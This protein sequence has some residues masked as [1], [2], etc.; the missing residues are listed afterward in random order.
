MNYYMSAAANLRW[1]F[2]C[3]V[4]YACSTFLATVHAGGAASFLCDPDLQQCGGGRADPVTSFLILTVVSAVVLF[5]WAAGNKSIKL[6]YIP[7]A[8]GSFLLSLFIDWGGLSP[9]GLVKSV[10]AIPGG[11][12]IVG[13]VVIFFLAMFGVIDYSL[14]E[15]K[16]SP[17]QEGKSAAGGFVD[18]AID[19]SAESIPELPSNSGLA[20]EDQFIDIAAEERL[21]REI[22]EFVGSVEYNRSRDERILKR[23]MGDK[24]LKILRVNNL[25][26]ENRLAEKGGYWLLEADGFSDVSKQIVSDLECIGF[27][28]ST[29]RNG[30]YLASLP[31][32][33][34]S[35][36]PSQRELVAMLKIRTL[37]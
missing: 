26:E 36:S 25:A 2:V 7:T 24:F 17:G 1:L 14:D 32:E 8:V 4:V 20:A 10:V 15:E 21:A 34:V 29:V 12:L 23:K 22:S 6:I 9:W 18:K 19:R 13:W 31:V 30:W 28:R 33:D 11:G 37:I 35:L 3:I 27:A 16:R 5:G